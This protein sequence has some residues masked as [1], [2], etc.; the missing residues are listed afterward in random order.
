MDELE[1]LWYKLNV[2]LKTDGTENWSM[3]TFVF[4]QSPVLVKHR[5]DLLPF[6]LDFSMI[7]DDFICSFSISF[8]RGK[9]H[10]NRIFFQ[11]SMCF[12]GVLAQHCARFVEVES[13][14]IRRSKS[15]PKEEP[16]KTKSDCV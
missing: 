6:Q 2:G 13:C 1:I 9:Y 5:Y 4:S 12:L 11:R 3:R 16:K 7:Y 14:S 10:R 15:K 8:A